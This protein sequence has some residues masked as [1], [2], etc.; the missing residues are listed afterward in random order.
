MDISSY[1]YPYNSMVIYN[2][3]IY[4]HLVEMFKS[5]MGRGGSSS[6]AIAC[7]LNGV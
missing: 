1:T 6:V 5:E 3:C 4:L 7:D 2:H